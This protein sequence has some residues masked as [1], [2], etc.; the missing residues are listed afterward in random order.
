MPTGRD[1]NNGVPDKLNPDNNPPTYQFSYDDFDNEEQPTAPNLIQPNTTTTSTTTT[2]TSSDPQA[3]LALENERLHKLIH[4]LL[5]QQQDQGSTT[6][7]ANT[8]LYRLD[9]NILN[10]L[11]LLDEMSFDVQSV[12]QRSAIPDGAEGFTTVE[13][14][15]FV[16]KAHYSTLHTLTQNL[17]NNLHNSSSSSTTTTSNN[18]NNS[19]TT[20]TTT[21]T[22]TTNTDAPLIPSTLEQQQQ[23]QTTFSANHNN[24]IRTTEM[25]GPNDQHRGMMEVPGI[26]PHREHFTEELPAISSVVNDYFN[27]TTSIT[28]VTQQERILEEPTLTPFTKS[29]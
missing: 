24:I 16:V 10:N 29:T 17:L 5:L 28:I 18:T 19:P 15:D 9:E 4:L 11:S 20:T 1:N 14:D 3:D 6:T 7:T 26:P 23:L 22:T 27:A 12:P 2:T 21:T 25:T 8:R 13:H